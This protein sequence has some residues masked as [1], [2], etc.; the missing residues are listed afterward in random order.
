MGSCGPAAFNKEPY[1]VRDI[2]N[3][4]NY[5]SFKTVLLTSNLLSCWSLPLI[6]AK[7]SLLGTLAVY[8]NS[9]KVPDDKERDLV[10][11]VSAFLQILIE[12]HQVKE[13]LLI[14]NERYKY[15]TLAT[16]DATY[17]WNMLNEYLYWGEGAAK[18]FGY[19]EKKSRIEDW[20]KR[21]HP[22][23]RD[24]INKSLSDILAN[25]NVA[26]WHQE[27]R[28]QRADHS[29]AFVI[30]DGYIIRN[31]TG[32]PI[33]MVGVLKD[34]TKL[35]EDANQILR[36]NKRLQEIARINSHSIRKPLANV[37]G[38]INTLKYADAELIQE[39]MVML[40]ESG[41]ELDKVIRTI[42]KK[43]VF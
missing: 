31:Q 41:E 18:L 16:N 38:I 5:G 19:P 4:P 37:L 8:H 32:K 1:F 9:V 43:T 3:H 2:E 36:Q 21:I 39:L 11:R 30:E 13:R 17:D 10:K 24:R 14:S 15:I 27:Y 35:K 26:Y 7:G 29:Y 12:S 40:E 33:R 22:A 6:N 25:T 20:E 23:D 28:Y 34:I 42:A